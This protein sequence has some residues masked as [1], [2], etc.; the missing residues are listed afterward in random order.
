MVLF[1]N[2]QPIKGIAIWKPANNRAIFKAKAKLTA[3]E[4]M[5]P[6]I[7]TAKASIASP[8]ARRM[9]DK[10]VIKIFPNFYMLFN[11]KMIIMN[12]I[13]TIGLMK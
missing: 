5:P 12:N 2:H 4:A 7:E 11:T 3:G 1:P 10:K 6:V 13:L 8:K 9:E